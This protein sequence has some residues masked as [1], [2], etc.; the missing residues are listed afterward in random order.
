MSMTTAMKAVDFAI[1]VTPPQQIL[2]FC[3]FGG[4]PLLRFDLIKEITHYIRE[5][6]V[7]SGPKIRIS[8]TTN[9]TLLDQDIFDF[10]RDQNINLCISAD[11]PAD[12][13]DLNRKFKNGEGSFTIV[14]NNLTKAAVQLDNLQVNAV[15]GTD[16]VDFVPES[17]R[18]FVELGVPVIHLNPSI[19]CAW[20]QD[21]YPRLAKSYSEVADYYIDCYQQGHEIAINLL[22]SKAIL[23]LKKGYA[24][25]DRCS[26]GEN[27]WAIAPS[28]N[29][30]PCERL[31]GEDRDTSMCLGN[32]HFGIDST[33]RCLIIKNRGNS[34]EE[35]SNCDMQQ[36]CMNWC[37]CT[38][39][40]MTGRTDLMGAAMC[41]SERAAIEA[42]KR[43]FSTLSQ[44][45]NDLYIDHLLRYA[46]ESNCVQ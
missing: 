11:G 36:Y 35:C 7:A 9:G 18:F 23:F 13:H 3:F 21:I 29:I 31:I 42:A 4:E 37:G 12:V 6:T 44:N 22:D 28:G 15:F 40:H 10:I 5:H 17:V 24:R 46:Q 32:I 30:Y 25:Q 43:V 39:Y 20:P 26:M 19:T 38:N 27:E 33:R 41:A 1:S 2:E 45:G 8:I 16:T 34:N 14:E